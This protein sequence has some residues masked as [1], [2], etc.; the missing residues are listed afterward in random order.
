MAH[1]NQCAT[2]VS[3][4][5]AWCNHLQMGQSSF[6]WWSMSCI[7]LFAPLGC[8]TT[9]AAP[10]STTYEYTELDMQRLVTGTWSGTWDAGDAGQGPVP[11]TLPRSTLS[12]AAIFL[13]S[14]EALTWADT[15]VGTG[16]TALGDRLARV[17]CFFKA[18][19]HFT[20]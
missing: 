14:G 18:P 3:A 4:P 19:L 11:F 20:E 6:S 5:R 8:G 1:S 15:G 2:L 7:I 9:K 13:A 17:H 12:S 16:A 10:G